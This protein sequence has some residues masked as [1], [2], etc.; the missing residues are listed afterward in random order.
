MILAV[1]A[2][3]TVDCS[4]LL[5]RLAAERG[6]QPV[7]DPGREACAAFGFQTLYDLPDP[8]QRLV[9]TDLLKR[10]AR[11]VCDRGDLLL[12]FSVV[13][14]LADWMR[15]FWRGTSTDEWEHVLALGAEA[16]RRYDVVYHVEGNDSRPYDGYAW[17]DRRNAR[18]VNRLMLYLYGEL[19]IG[20]RVRHEDLREAGD[21]KPGADDADHF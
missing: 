5:A 3:P 8:L 12:G 2:A 1:S 19:G 20:S 10:H 14:W 15:W 16:A 21:A 11:L 13:E 17:L 18:Q 7:P 6:L 9:R 4:R